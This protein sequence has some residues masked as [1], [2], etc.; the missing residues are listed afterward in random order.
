MYIFNFVH[1]TYMHTQI[2]YMCMCLYVCTYICIV[3]RHD[4]NGL[5]KLKLFKYMAQCTCEAIN[6]QYN[7]TCGVN[8]NIRSCS[9]YN[10]LVLRIPT[11]RDFRPDNPSFSFRP[12]HII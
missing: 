2:I 3:Y 8:A 9:V 12:R 10:L 1:C 5:T 6:K 4:H 11:S 7:R